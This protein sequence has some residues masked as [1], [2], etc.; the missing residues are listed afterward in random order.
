MTPDD[1]LDE[2]TFP[3]WRDAIAAHAHESPAPRAY[4]GYPRWPLPRVKGSMFGGAS[5][6]KTLAARRASGALADELPDVRDLGRVL[7]LA[8]GVT[9]DA[10]R[11]PVPSAGGLQALEIYLAAWA[12]GWLPGGWY[13][14]DR[15]A[16]ALAQV[17]A[18]ATRATVAAIVPSLE[19]VH[20]GAL[21]W[22]L[23]G[24]HARV[25]A[26]Y[27]RRALRFLT[28]EAGHLMQNLCL[29]SHAAKLCTI[30]LGG[31]FERPISRALQLPRTD[32]I[33]YAGVLGRPL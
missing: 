6:D 31:F 17:T 10:A 30:P 32:R 19:L 13:H 15:S 4:P 7:E 14:F 18:G 2:T 25:A 33:L 24:D 26:R 12:T 11:G 1:D 3:A 27:G 9:G 29:V 8:H 21:C 28:L 23:V 22:I 5:L 16:H 20:G